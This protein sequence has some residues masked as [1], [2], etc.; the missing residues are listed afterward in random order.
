MPTVVVGSKKNHR[1]TYKV[2]R[3]TVAEDSSVTDYRARNPHD[4][5]EVLADVRELARWSC[6]FAYDEKGE[7]VSRVSGLIWPQVDGRTGHEHASGA[8]KYH[9]DR[10]KKSED[11]LVLERWTATVRNQVNHG[12]GKLKGMTEL[13]ADVEIACHARALVDTHS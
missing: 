9:I 12:V 10:T 2:T 4:I 5:N 6:E 1:L 13:S 8:W 7:K 3:V 11:R